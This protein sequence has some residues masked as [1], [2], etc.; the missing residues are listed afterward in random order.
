MSIRIN[1]TE[2]TRRLIKNVMCEF[3]KTKLQNRQVD[4]N[5]NLTNKFNDHTLLTCENKEDGFRKVSII[6]MSLPFSTIHAAI[7]NDNGNI[8]LHDKPFFMSANAAKKKIINFLIKL[9][10]ENLSTT[11]KIILPPDKMKGLRKIVELFKFEKFN[12]K[13]TVEGSDSKFT[14][15]VLDIYKNGIDFRPS[16]DVEKNFN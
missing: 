2:Q 12:L 10:P 6:H 3:K 1:G 5:F 7:G 13:K 4:Y 8:L 11:M 9:Q 15:E 16:L 14:M